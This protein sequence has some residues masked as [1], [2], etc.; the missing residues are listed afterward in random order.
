MGCELFSVEVLAHD[1]ALERGVT[2]RRCE[3]SQGLAHRLLIAIA[4]AKE[5]DTCGAAL[6]YSNCDVQLHEALSRDHEE[7]RPHISSIPFQG[8]FAPIKAIFEGSK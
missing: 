8:S 1:F 5:C 7:L 3:F 4:R 2:A 6:T